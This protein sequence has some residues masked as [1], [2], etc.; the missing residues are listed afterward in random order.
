LNASLQRGSGIPLYLQLSELLKQRLLSSEWTSGSTLP[1]ELELCEEF[2][3]AR[4]TVR[5]ALGELESAKYIRRVQGHGTIVIW[6]DEPSQP[7]RISDNQIGLVVPYVRDSFVST[8]LLGMERSA[9]EKG[10]S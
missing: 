6:G 10:L 4:G 3:V 1:S 7:R 8:I 9:A 2:G 5:Q